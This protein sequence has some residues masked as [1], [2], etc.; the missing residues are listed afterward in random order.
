MSFAVLMIN[1]RS[2]RKN[3][4]Q[5]IA[6]FCNVLSYFSCI[7]L[8]ETWLTEHIDNVFNIPGFYCFNLYRNN[9]GGGIKMYFRNS[10]QARMLEDFTFI[11]NYFEMLTVELIFGTNKAVMCG[12]YHPPTSSIENNNAFIESLAN[13]LRLLGNR[14]VPLLLA[15]DLNINL[16][17]PSNMVYVNTFINTMFELGL[18]PVITGPT[19]INVESSNTRF[20]LID[21]I[22]TS[23]SII[24]VMSCIFPLGITD[25]F[26]VC[27]FIRFPFDS[28]SENQ[29]HYFRKLCLRGK[30][31]FSLLLSNINVD[32]IQGNL[33][34][35]YNNY[36]TKIF[37]CY[38][39]AFP[40]KKSSVKD[41]NP[42]P[43]MTPQ[44]RQCISKKSKLYRLYLKGRINRNEYVSFKNQLTAVIRR[45]KKL[46]YSKILFEASCDIKRTWSCLNQIMERNMHPTLKELKVGNT[47]LTGKEL[48][49]YINNY[50]VNA[51]NIITANL[52]RAPFNYFLTAAIDASCFFLSN[53]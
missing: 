42:A 53:D 13:V 52:L 43:W 10:I 16:L 23:G 8:T 28:A 25:H 38:D 22:W 15:G 18:S 46:Y 3:F 49:N 51:V 41:K 19:K 44:L 36:V 21:H 14:K 11:N 31:T 2:C 37:D 12:L 27:S 48:A 6:Y 29:G 9:F 17:N 45:V 35:S 24:S 40:I 30:L 33:N 7:I 32:I 4:S 5:F 50:F 26:P 47:I 20:S 1:I 39:T 34:L